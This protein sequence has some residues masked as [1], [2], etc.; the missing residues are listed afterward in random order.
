[1]NIEYLHNDV[2]PSWRLSMMESCKAGN[3]VTA[4]CRTLSTTYNR[5]RAPKIFAKVNFDSKIRKAYKV[6]SFTTVCRI[7]LFSK[8]Q[9]EY[10]ES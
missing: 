8:T 5:R 7:Q 3:A 2:N 4:H 10:R 1:M 6:K 9:L